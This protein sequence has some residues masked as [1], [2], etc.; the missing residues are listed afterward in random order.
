[1]ILA[2]T[3]GYLDRMASGVGVQDEC[4]RVYDEVKLGHR[5]LYVIFRVSESLQIVVEEKGGHDRTYDDFV[6]RL[7]E[8]ERKRQCRYGI[9][10][11]RFIQNDVPQEKLAFFLWSP[12]T[13]TIKQKMLYS[14]SKQ[15]LRNQMRGIHAEIQCNDDADLAMSNVLERCMRKYT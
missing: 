9:F 10:D 5:W 13:A 8:A 2:Y 1:M 15:A 11:V 3:C 12:E 14:S 7:K 6:A 4:L